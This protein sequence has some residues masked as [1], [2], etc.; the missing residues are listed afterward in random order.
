M[1]KK[2]CQLLQAAVERLSHRN[3]TAHLT[4][5][6]DETPRLTSPISSNS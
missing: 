3:A 2:R 6:L 5:I 4:N 1:N